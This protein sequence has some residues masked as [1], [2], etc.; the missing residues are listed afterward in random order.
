MNWVVSVILYEIEPN[1]FLSNEKS[2]KK[3]NTELVDQSMYYV[4]QIKRNRLIL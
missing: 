2:I 1:R 3:N 4:L